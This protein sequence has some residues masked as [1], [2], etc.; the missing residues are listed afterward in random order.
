MTVSR[1]NWSQRNVR[2]LP[3]KVIGP[4]GD[5]GRAV[6]SISARHDYNYSY[7]SY[8]NCTLGTAAY[9]TGLFVAFAP[10]RCSTVPQSATSELPG[11]P[12]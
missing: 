12:A 2:R 3:A 9:F 7:Y 6:G 8:Y 11:A 1:S 5:N 4:D 10:F